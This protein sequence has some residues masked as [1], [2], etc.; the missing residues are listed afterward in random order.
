MFYRETRYSSLETKFIGNTTGLIKHKDPPNV[1]RRRLT[2]S[3]LEQYAIEE[4]LSKK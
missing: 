4:T 2:G 1:R 3:K